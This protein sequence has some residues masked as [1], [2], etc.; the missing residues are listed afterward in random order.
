MVNFD[1]VAG[2]PGITLEIDGLEFS[3]GDNVG[4]G[5]TDVDLEFDMDGNEVWR[6]ESF[7][8][9]DNL[10]FDTV[11][12]GP[13]LDTAEIG[14]AEDVL[15]LDDNAER[16]ECEEVGSEELDDE[17][18]VEF[19]A[20][21]E[22][23][24]RDVAKIFKSIVNYWS[25]PTLSTPP[26]PN[27]LKTLTFLEGQRRGSGRWPHININRM[28]PY[29]SGSF[30]HHWS[31]LLASNRYWTKTPDLFSCLRTIKVD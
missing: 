25:L 21:L 22:E 15:E 28:L 13:E 4:T 26:T 12:D 10:G 1:D 20:K 7:L 9:H 23:A 5:R 30:A 6:A 16:L 8:K 17:L 11:E 2:R 27:P 31:V 29:H 19:K 18:I 14:R 3:N 24:E